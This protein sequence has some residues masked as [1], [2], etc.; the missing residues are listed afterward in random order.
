MKLLIYSAN[1]GNFDKKQKNKEQV[2]PEG[3][4]QID[5][6]IF[7]DENFPPRFNSM[8]PR[9]QARICKMMAWQMKPDYDYYLWVD[10]S[11]RL[12]KEASAKWFL[13]Q[14]GDADI[15]VFKHNKRNT[16]RQEAEYLW[17]RLELERQGRKKPYI[18]PRYDGERT[19]DQMAVVD[20]DAE[21]YASTAFIC[22]NNLQVQDLMTIWWLH[23]SLYHSIDQL[24]LPTAIK[25]SG[26]KTNVIREDYLKCKYLEYTRK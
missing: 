19:D 1:L 17:E 13:E 7:T 2:L 21:L 24:S 9:L 8:T 5:Y 4:D 18:L 6:H 26:A 25:H 16:V 14:L 3:V 11:C 15:A 12:S 23:T 20:H 10:S 22:R